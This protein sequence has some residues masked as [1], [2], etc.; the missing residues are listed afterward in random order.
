M[1]RLLVCL[2]VLV[3]CTLFLT[4]ASSFAQTPP[5]TSEQSLQE[6]VKE[7][8]QLRATLQRMNATVYKGQMIMERL[9]LHQEQV[10]R[11]ERELRE[12]RDNL[13]DLQSEEMKVKQMLNHADNGVKAGT[14]NE[15]ELVSLKAEYNAIRERQSR[16][17][18]RESQLSVELSG[19][20]HTLNALNERLNLL[21]EREL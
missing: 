11:I 2:F 4:P 13:S 16:A 15:T 18:M 9:K 5:A 8:R 10:N 12:T 6:L 17:R 1:K 19:E 20:R 14:T 3:A 21:L 7:V